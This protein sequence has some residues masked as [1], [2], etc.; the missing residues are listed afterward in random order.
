[1]SVGIFVRSFFIREFNRIAVTEGG[2]AYL[3]YAVFHFVFFARAYFFHDVGY[4]VNRRI[5]GFYADRSKSGK[6]KNQ[7]KQTGGY[8][9]FPYSFHL[10]ITP[11]KYS[12]SKLYRFLR[13][14]RRA[15]TR[16]LC[17]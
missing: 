13:R 4:I 14:Q 7:R 9:C 2:S 12:V 6:D 10:R 17:L 1:M 16:P 15:E 5:R 8:K 3:F 11:A